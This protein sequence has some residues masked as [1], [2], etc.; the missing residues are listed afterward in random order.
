MLDD[1]K[2]LDEI[3]VSGM[4][5]QMTDL[6]AQLESSLSSKI[7]VGPGANRLCLC[8][9]GGSAMGADVLSDHMQRT[10]GIV[11]EVVR[12]VSLPGWVDADTL[13]VLMSYS[14]NTRETLAMYDEARRR[15][16]RIVTITSGGR[17][18]KLSEENRHPHVKVPSGIQPRAALGHLLGAAASVVGAA[19]MSSVG[20]DLR[21]MLPALREEVASLAPGNPESTNLAKQLAT[22]LHDRVPFIY[23]SRETRPAGR[24]WQT[25]INENSKMLCLYGELP[26]AD[27][28]Q[29]VG[30]VDGERSKVARPVFLRAA[31]DRGMIADI[32]RATISIFEDFGLEPVIVDLKGRTPLENVMRGMILGDHVSYYL[33]M[34]KGVDPTPVSSISELKKRLG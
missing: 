20:N 27:H 11:T 3:D 33:A 26:E 22:Q 29:V 5:R 4:L 31:S 15:D 18:L 19:G 10:T 13:V 8:G 28:N 25:Q 21:D 30:W 24:R 16:A 9:L 2:A 6:P 32:V 23:S 7:I 17:L 34:L 14:G 12:D 1:E